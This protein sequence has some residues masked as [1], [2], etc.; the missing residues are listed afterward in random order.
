MLVPTTR[1]IRAST[2]AGLVRARVASLKNRHA[3]SWGL[4]SGCARTRPTATSLLGAQRGRNRAAAR[5]SWW[6]RSRFR[7][8][9]AAGRLWLRALGE[10]NDRDPP[11]GLRCV[12]AVGRVRCKH[13]VGEGPESSTLGFVVDHRRTHR[14]AAERYVW[15]RQQIVKPR[16]M[17]RSAGKRSDDGHSVAESNST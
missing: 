7:R 11:A 16:R 1:H 12:S 13:A 17:F 2:N 10:L 5:C 6:R 9:T 8:R 4:A 3:R 15:M 14:N